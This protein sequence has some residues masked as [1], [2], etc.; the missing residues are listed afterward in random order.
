MLAHVFSRHAHVVDQLAGEFDHVALQP[1]EIG[2]LMDTG[3]PVR[4]L[5]EFYGFVCM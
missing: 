2:A 4:E 3:T 5:P 1:V